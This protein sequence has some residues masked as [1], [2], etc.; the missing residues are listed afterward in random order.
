MRYRK[1]VFLGDTIIGPEPLGIQRFTVELLR[2]LDKMSFPYKIE[3]LIPQVNN[4]CLQL[5]NIEIKKYGKKDR[6]GF[7]WRQLDFSRYIKEEKALAID[8]TLGLIWRG[9][10]IVCLH[11]CIYE[12]YP[13]DFV[14]IKAK[15]KRYSYLLRARR[16]VAFAKKILTVSHTS[17]NELINYY[18][19]SNEKVEVIYNGWQHI[20]KIAEDCHILKK[21]GLEVNNYIFSLGS[22]LPHKNFRWIIEAAK[23]N[24]DIIF[25]VTGSNRFGANDERFKE[26][27]NLIFTG[28]LS[29]AEIKS[30]MTNC[31]CFIFPS[32][33]EGFGIPPLEAL[34]CGADILVSNKSC[35]PEIYTRSCVFFDPT[36]YENID[37]L[38][39]LESL[40]SN[41]DK[42]NTLDSYSWT[43][44]AEKIQNLLNQIM[45]E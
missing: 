30:L 14:G 37:I 39:M 4:C 12:N 23:Q 2:E 20:E 18:D 28:F 33:Y 38:K 17:E 31:K 35:L 32:L 27:N 10:D 7:F 36:K 44:S 1:V 13:Q 19:I 41:Q 15:I 3:V 26:I 21:L 45:K 40:P 24:A 6:I 11:D 34:A 42:K 8:L 25:V 9:S 29:D 16:N 22:Q 5:C 43:K